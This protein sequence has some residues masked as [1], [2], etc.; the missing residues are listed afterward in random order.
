MSYALKLA[1]R[2]LRARRQSLARLTAGA[3]VVGIAAGVA[4]LILAQALARGFA[5]E[6]RDK[7][8]AGTAHVSIFRADGAELENWAEIAAALKTGDDIR[9]VAPTAYENAVLVGAAAT[10][11]AVIKVRSRT[12]PDSPPPPFASHGARLA[13]D[14]AADE[15]AVGARLAEKLDLRIG[16]RAEI[17]TLDRPTPAPVRV[18]EIFETGLYDYDAAWVYVGPENYA[19]LNGRLVFTPTTLS[20]SVTDL[21]RSDETAARLRQTLGADFRVV[22]WQEAN[23]PLF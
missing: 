3:A 6:M 20:V 7:I 21:Y 14:L 1:F 2:Y 17:A 10:S 19:R 22:D 8:L 15:V 18:A 13:A 4:S 5:D 12:A 11:Y 9:A 16:D 23:R